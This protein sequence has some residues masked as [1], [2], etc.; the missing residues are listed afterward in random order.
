MRESDKHAEQSALTWLARF[1]SGHWSAADEEAHAKWLAADPAHPAT[2]LRARESWERL[3]DL[4]PL[5]ANELRAA[6][7]PHHPHFAPPR[8]RAGLALASLCALLIA[9]LPTVLPGSF[10]EVQSVQTARGEQRKLTL[11]DGSTVQLNTDT[12]VMIDYGLH[13]RCLQLLAGEMLVRVRHGDPR[14]FAVS[15]GTATVRD[16]GT[17]FSMRQDPAQTSVAVLEGAVEVSARPGS[18]FARLGAG[19]RLAYDNS[20]HRIGLPDIPLADLIAWREGSI[21]FRDTPLPQV[22]A[23]FGRYHAVNFEID[24]QLQDYRL[25][26]RFASKDLDSLLSLL[27]SAYPISIRRPTPERLRLEVRRS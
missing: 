24:S 21:V 26:G 23:E 16:I 27:R 11:A 17:E 13:C 3:A 9:L 6:R 14:A 22:L 18:A 20:G 7:R 4:R 5:A 1:H 2:W 19:E 15:A 12:R 8:W 10:S 25:S